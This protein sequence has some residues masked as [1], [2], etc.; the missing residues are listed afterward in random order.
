MD[1]GAQI[2]IFK[3]FVMLS[4]LSSKLAECLGAGAE[5]SGS[6]VFFFFSVPIGLIFYW[7]NNKQN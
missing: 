5:Q 1:G 2:Y 4:F 6:T 3:V 7:K